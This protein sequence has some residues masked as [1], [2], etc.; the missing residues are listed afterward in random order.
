LNARTTP[1]APLNTEPDSLYDMPGHLIRRC[2]QISVALFHQECAV[3]GI[4]PQQYAVLRVL[5][6]HD[7]EDQ[8]TLAGLAA[9][10]RTTAGEIV[11]RMEEAG[12]LTRRDGSADRRVKNLFITK[13]GKRLL[14][15]IHAAVRRVQERLLEPLDKTERRQF[16]ACLTRIADVNNELS[17]APLRPPRAGKKATSTRAA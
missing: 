10:N 13:E 7:G 3:Y 16:I 6:S 9:F 5:A 11:A 2:H 17:R 14:K 12:L 8:I 4:T 15:D 1:K